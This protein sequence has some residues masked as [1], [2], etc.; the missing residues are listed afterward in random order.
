MLGEKNRQN[1]IALFL[2][3]VLSALS[4]QTVQKSAVQV[5]VGQMT[6]ATM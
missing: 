4:E 3:H 5:V 2:Q 1:N 6:P